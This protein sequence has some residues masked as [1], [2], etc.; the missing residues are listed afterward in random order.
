VH[1]TLRLHQSEYLYRRAERRLA[2]DGHRLRRGSLL[3]LCVA[4]S[5]RDPQVFPDPERWDPTR[6]VD[7]RP[8]REEYM[9]FGA[10]GTSCLGAALAVQVARMFVIKLSTYRLGVAVDGP[11]EH[12]GWHWRPSGRF[13]VTL[14]PS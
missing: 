14:E 11:H 10:P 7:A 1:E 9:P 3:R 2:V 4:E 6:F 5:H 12:D 13:R 8:P